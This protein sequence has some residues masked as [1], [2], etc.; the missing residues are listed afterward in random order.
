MH[1]LAPLSLKFSNKATCCCAFLFSALIS[2]GVSIKSSPGAISAPTK[3]FWWG[4]IV[5][6]GIFLPTVNRNRGLMRQI[7]PIFPF[8]LLL[9]FLSPLHSQT[10]TV[11]NSDSTLTVNIRPHLLLKDFGYLLSSPFRSFPQNQL[12]LLGVMAVSAGLIWKGDEPIDEAFA[13]EP[14][15]LPYRAA[16]G[17]ADMGQ[18]YDYVN[19]AVYVAGISGLMGASAWLLKDQKLWK[20]TG[21]LLEAEIFTFWVISGMKATLGRARPFTNKGPHRFEPLQFKTDRAHLS[22]PS[23]HAAS[24]F[25]MAAVFS[26]QYPRWWV[27]IPAYTFAV[28]VA[29]QRMESR[30]HWASDVF[31]GSFLGYITAHLLVQRHQN[32]HTNKIGFHPIL[33]SRQFGVRIR[34]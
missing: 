5:F 22:M 34:F 23:M 30:E 3:H 27:K 33:N 2:I 29:F 28:S 18:L 12:S 6:N 24:I 7:N 20:T 13:I 26:K 1:F 8:V 25:A 19:G 4:Q 32:K 16:H 14:N 11:K 9:L 21:L 15:N 17:L 31:V 10:T